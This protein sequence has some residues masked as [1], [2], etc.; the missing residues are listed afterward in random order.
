MLKV[1]TVVRF[2][3]SGEDEIG[4]VIKRVPS[5]P[6]YYILV[7]DTETTIN[8]DIRLLDN[9]LIQVKNLNVFDLIKEDLR[10]VIGKRKKGKS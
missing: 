10:K 9:N 5:S 1:G 8:R 4:I 7:E 2:R 3:Q 6:L